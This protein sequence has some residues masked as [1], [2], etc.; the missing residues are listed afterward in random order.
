M[1]V[2]LAYST[3]DSVV[4][5]TCNRYLY[6]DATVCDDITELSATESGSI[7]YP[8]NGVYAANM[9]CLW[10]LHAPAGM[11]NTTSSLISLFTARCY[12][13]AVYT[14]VACPSF[15]PSVTRQNFV[16]KQLNVKSRKQRHIR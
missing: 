12:A 10:R 15:R 13:S 11:V 2:A 3:P 4:T 16:P 14:V 9:K 5:Y 1:L 6:F 7:V 8:T